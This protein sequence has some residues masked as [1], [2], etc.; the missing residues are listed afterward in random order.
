MFLP[1]APGAA[2]RPEVALFRAEPLAVLGFANRWPPTHF[3]SKH[4]GLWRS[5]LDR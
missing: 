2:P 5:L 4:S 3:T 1:P